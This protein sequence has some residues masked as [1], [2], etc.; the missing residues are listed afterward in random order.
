VL[1]CDRLPLCKGHTYTAMRG[2]VFD[3]DGARTCVYDVRVVVR[4]Y[5]SAYLSTC[6]PVCM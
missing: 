4:A 2:S 3:T 1:L 6:L 5:L